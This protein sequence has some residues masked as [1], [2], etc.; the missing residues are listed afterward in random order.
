[1]DWET[2]ENKLKTHRSISTVKSSFP[3]KWQILHLRGWIVQHL[4]KD[5][6]LVTF[7]GLEKR[8]F[9]EYLLARGCDIFLFDIELETFY[10]F[11]IPAPWDLVLQMQAHK[12]ES[13]HG[14]SACHNN[15]TTLLFAHDHCQAEKDSCSDPLSE[16]QHKRPK[17]IFL[18]CH[19]KCFPEKELQEWGGKKNSLGQRETEFTVSSLP[20]SELLP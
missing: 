13:L 2:L 6:Q 1:M 20:L 4:K 14:H 11:S 9:P 5:F 17:A 12:H 8:P 10:L 19:H 7:K 15:S 18:F 3:I 16:D